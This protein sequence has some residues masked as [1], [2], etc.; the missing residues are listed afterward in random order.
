MFD[1]KAKKTIFLVS[2]ILLVFAMSCGNDG[3]LSGKYEAENPDRE[4]AVVILEL[5]PGG[6]GVWS[7][8]ENE[9]FF[10]W[11]AGGGGIRLRT[12]S[13]GVIEGKIEAGSIRIA[14]PGTG[15]FLFRPVKAR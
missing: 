6:K 13:G 2:S 4:N 15:E 14:L 11:D 7:F 12:K 5:K 1:M 9:A 8:E 3:K 10:K